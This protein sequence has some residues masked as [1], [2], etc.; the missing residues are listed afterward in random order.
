MDGR[1]IS[2]QHVAEISA[3]DT[4]GYW[5]YAV[6]MGHVESLLRKEAAARGEWSYLDLGCGAGGVMRRVVD[7]LGPARAMG[8]D[9]TQEAVDIAASR[10]SDARYADF[11][12]PLGLDF[13]PQV[14]T[15]LD[16]LEHLEDPVLALKHLAA[17][18]EPGALL[19]ATVP[20]QPGLWSP[21]DEACGHHRRYTRQTLAEH[22]AAAGWR[23]DR[24]RYFFSY[25]VPPAWW[26]RRVRKTVQ[27]M[28]FPP[29]SPLMNRALS[30]AGRV[31]RALGSPLPFGTSLIASARPA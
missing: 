15:C 4:A 3:A 12:K 27:E 10:G 1:E 5:W 19:V 8:L 16:V 22:L 9:G 17:E 14:V 2:S 29:V 25:C 7:S 13:H 30:V 24:V 11:R 6:R 23:V 26:E 28:E 21:W 18:V 20:A 31:E